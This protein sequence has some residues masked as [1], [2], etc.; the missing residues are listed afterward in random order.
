MEKGKSCTSFL[1]PQRLDV[2]FFYN[3]PELTHDTI[4][5]LS[6]NHLFNT[7]LIRNHG[8]EF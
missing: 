8:D 3:K 4:K 7:N 6:H 2:R 5:N 1:I